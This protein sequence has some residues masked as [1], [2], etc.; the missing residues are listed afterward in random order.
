MMLLAHGKLFLF[1]QTVQTMMKCRISPGFHCLPKYLF[2]GIHNQRVH[3][4]IVDK[5]IRHVMLLPYQS[6]YSRYIANYIVAKQEA[7]L[8][9][10]VPKKS[11][12]INA[13]KCYIMVHFLS[14]TNHFNSKEN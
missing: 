4:Q 10:K 11:K 13:I 8:M 5:S 7:S 2:A 9:K 1:L 14:Y 3:L 6:I 12:L